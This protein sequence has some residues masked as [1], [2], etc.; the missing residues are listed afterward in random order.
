MLYPAILTDSLEVAEQQLLTAQELEHISVAQIDVVDGFYAD[1]VTITP[2]DLLQT[3][4]GD[5]QLDFHF[6]VNEPVDFLLETAALQSALPIRAMI[7]QIEHMG[8][9]AEYLQEVAR[10]HWQAG[11]SLDVYTPLEA[12]D[13][14]S[15]NDIK[16]LQILGN[17]GG[18]Q[19]QAFN[20]LVL[21]KI[22]EARTAITARHLEIELVVDIGVKLTTATEI[23]KAGATSLVVGSE[24][25]KSSQPEEIVRQ[26]QAL[27]EE[28]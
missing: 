15:W 2:E 26:Y 12:I 18:Y 22:N 7:A 1:N 13:D 28:V 11:L 14:S 16:M 21:E 27:F 20:P 3:D 8:S 25:W 4:F 23:L 24:L 5:L 9:Q 17:A 10:H 6:L 19:G